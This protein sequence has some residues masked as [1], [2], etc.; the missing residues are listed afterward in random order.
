MSQSTL[1]METH[2]CLPK[3][4]DR[5]AHPNNRVWH[6][7][8]ILESFSSDNEKCSVDEAGVYFRMF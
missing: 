5:A 8:V 2:L 7:P 4:M 1:G 3:D 6:D